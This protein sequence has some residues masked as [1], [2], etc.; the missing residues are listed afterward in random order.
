MIPSEATRAFWF[1][2]ESDGELKPIFLEIA[3]NNGLTAA[4]F[5]AC[6]TDQAALK[7]LNGRVQAA[8]DAGVDSTPTFFIGGEKHEG[9]MTLDQLDAAIAEAAKAPPHSAART[10]TRKRG[11]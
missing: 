3:N 10:K 8:I 11:G 6:L 9:E 4:Q 5:E 1:R 7:A 2:S